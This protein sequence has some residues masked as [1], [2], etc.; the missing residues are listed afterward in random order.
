[1]QSAECRYRSRPRG[2]NWRGNWG[3]TGSYWIVGR[4]RSRDRRSN[5]MLLRSENQARSGAESDAE[6]LDGTRF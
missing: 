5:H 3:G 6:G 2:R 4:N 1:M